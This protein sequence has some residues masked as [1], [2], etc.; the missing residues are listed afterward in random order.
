MTILMEAPDGPHIPFPMPAKP[1]SE[2]PHMHTHTNFICVGCQHFVP[3]LIIYIT[4]ISSQSRFHSW[5][6]IY[7]IRVVSSA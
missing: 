6:L 5:A 2:H 4:G 1:T 7:L 3:N